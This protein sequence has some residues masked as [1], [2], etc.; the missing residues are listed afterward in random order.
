MSKRGYILAVVIFLAA[1]LSL[2]AQ[3]KSRYAN[4]EKGFSIEF[5]EGWALREAP[6][7]AVVVLAQSP[8][9][10]PSDTFGENINIAVEDLPRDATTVQY[11]A[12]ARETLV[13]A[14]Q[15]LKV[16]DEGTLE[17]DGCQA[18]YF[19]YT[20]SLQGY[21]LHNIVYYLVVE[22]KAY[23]ITCSATDKSFD[24]FKEKFEKAVATFKIEISADKRDEIRSMAQ[25]KDARADMTR[26][27]SG[28][29]AFSVLFPDDWTVTDRGITAA[30]VA[31]SPSEGETDKY[32]ES[33]TVT[34]EIL[35]ETTT[36]ELYGKGLLTTLERKASLFELV[37]KEPVNV[38][39]L[40]GRRIVY[41][42]KM[43][44][45]KFTTTL[46]YAIDGP[47]AYLISCAALTDS[48]EQY[49]DVFETIARSFKL[50]KASE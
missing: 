1:T 23:V 36:I 41:T 4:R 37:G 2:E 35:A 32:S 48:Y 14:A 3:E 31:V 5:P 6:A 49:K 46:H 20:L 12:A 18:G 34:V 47:R 39:G 50:E 22:R 24:A 8:Q 21:S 29:Y 9:E 45:Y 19:G 16:L 40:D 11:G 27:T 43:G 26:Y 17:I 38:A 7:P 44:P 15:G 28:A 33:V 25:D 10:G 30:V 42:S 13:K